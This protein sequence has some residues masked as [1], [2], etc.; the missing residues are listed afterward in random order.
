MTGGERGVAVAPGVAGTLRSP[1][2]AV[3]PAHAVRAGLASLSLVVPLHD[4]EQRFGEFAP[5]LA[6]FIARFPPGSELIF[7]DDGSADATAAAV[8]RFLAANRGVPARL[9]RRR[10]EGKGAAVAAGLSLAS[11]RYAGFCDIDL[12]TP[13]A[14]FERL[15]RVAERGAVLA[16]GSR[17]LAGSRITHHQ[18]PLRE[19]LGRTYNRLVQMALTPGIVDTQCGAKVASREVWARILPYCREP[20]FSWDV[21]AISVARRLRIPVQE[22]AVEWR[23][24]D[25]SRVRLLRDGP[26]MVLAVPRIRRSLRSIEPGGE[27]APGGTLEWAPTGDGLVAEATAGIFDDENAQILMTRDSEHWWFRSKASLVAWALKRW[28]RPQDARSWLVDVGGGSGGV[29]RM[30]GWNPDRTLLVEGAPLLVRAARERHGL[31]GVSG[32]AQRLPVA[33]AS[34]SVVCL[35]DV[36]E[37]LHDPG[38]A[39]RE[40]S[41][42]LEPGGRLVVTVP[43]HPGLWSRADEFLGHRRRYTVR[44]V[45]RELAAIGYRPLFVSHV[46]GWLFVPVWLVRRFSRGAQRQM[47]LEWSGRRLDGMALILTRLERSLLRWIRLPLGTSILCVAA[48][49]DAA[50]PAGGAAAG[51]PV[52]E[53]ENGSRTATSGR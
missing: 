43:A 14:A 38:P 5:E 8:D 39:L 26:A 51:S 37:H 19:A 18:S 17:D 35:L 42:I 27:G 10:H 21:E 24:D 33:P 31:L 23:H 2:G 15:L 29:T 32:L 9:I 25:R 16:I 50:S 7:V 34:V 28:A 49:S 30:I 22:V 3:P 40:A 36:I 11:A 44:M 53:A 20:G 4:E 47:G 46:F 12:S 6:A 48:R 1:A 41:R 52:R 45:R 13:L